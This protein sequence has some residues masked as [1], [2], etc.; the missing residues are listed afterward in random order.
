MVPAT[1][2]VALRILYNLVL[3]T[4]QWGDLAISPFCNEG[5]EVD[6]KVK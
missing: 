3:T 1:I 5:T 6:R 4:I 2:L